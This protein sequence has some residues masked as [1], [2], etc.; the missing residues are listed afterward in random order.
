MN[1][2]LVLMLLLATL[3]VVMFIV[4]LDKVS[5][6]IEQEPEL[7]S[8]KVRCTRSRSKSPLEYH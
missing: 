5:E 3:K 1:M 6:L 4:I 7:P 8:P 2:L